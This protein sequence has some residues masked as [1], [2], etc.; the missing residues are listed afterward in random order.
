M[1]GSVSNLKGQGAVRDRLNRPLRDL[2]ISVI[3]R[4]NYRCPYCMPAEIYGEGH[5]FLPRSHWLTPGEIK[6][7]GGLF[8]QLGATKFR[9]T[10]GEPLLRRG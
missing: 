2:R 5:R 4:C 6:R 8:A 1:N 7:I 9:L 3:D 10:G